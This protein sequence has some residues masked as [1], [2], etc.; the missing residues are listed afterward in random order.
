M[1]QPSGKDPVVNPAVSRRETPDL[2]QPTRTFDQNTPDNSGN[3]SSNLSDENPQSFGRYR[4]VAMLGKGG[5]GAVYR[6]IDEQLERH[7]AIKVT[8][9]SMLDSSTRNG[10][11]TEA[12][13]VAALD[14]PHIVPVYDVGQTDAGDFFVVSKLVDGSDLAKR[15]K[16][17]PPDR[18][19]SLRIIEQVADALHYAHAKG[20]VHRDVKPANILLDQQDRPYLADFGLA[21]RETE[22]RRAGDLSG[23]PAYMSPEQ[24]RGEGHRID[25]RSDIYS[26]GVVLYELLAGRRPFRSDNPLDLMMLIATEEVRSPRLFDDTISQDLERICMKALAR[27]VCDRFAVARDLAEEIRWLL[28]NHAMTPGIRPMSIAYPAG[29]TPVTPVT[30]NTADLAARATDSQRTGPPRI[31]PKGLRSFD[32][33]D[34]SFFLEL[35]PGPLDREGLPEGLRFWKSR[36]EETDPE[37]TFK[38][39]LVYG[40]SGC[41][42]SSLMKAGLLPRLSPRIIPIYL[43]V[44]PDDTETRLLRAVRKAIPDAEGDSLKE[45]LRVIRRRKLVPTGGKLLL[46]LDQFEQWLFGEKDFAKAQLTDALLQCDGANVQAIVMVRDDFWLSVSRFLRELEISIERSNSALVD[47]F[48]PDHAAKVLGLFGRAY[49]KL[50]AS[51]RD[52]SPDQHE[53]IRQAVQSLSQDRKIISVRI[54][55]L[56]DM[57]KSRAW[58]TAALREVGGIEGIGV[59]FLEETFGSRHA[60]IQHRQH[61]EGV[62]GLLSALMPIKGADLKGSMRNANSL[63][64]AAGYERRPLEFQELMGILVKDLRLITPVDDGNSVYDA[65]PDQ[66]LP[67]ENSQSYQL[68]H[69]YMVPSLRE[70]LTQKQ[71]ETKK[72]RA[73][74]KLA[75]RTAVWNANQEN[76]QLPT[77]LEWLQIRRWTDKGRWTASEQ[78]LMRTAARVH[79]K[80]WGSTLVAALILGAVIG[81]LFQQQNL[82]SQREK[83]AV[84]L[85]SIQNTAGP[86][87]PSNIARLI[88]MRRPDLVR[89]ELERRYAAAIEPREKLSLAFALAAFGQVE[90][91]YLISQLDVIQDRDTGNL[92]RALR[93]DRQG[94]IEKLTHAAGECE[95]PELWQRRARLSLAALGVGDAALPV[96]ACEFEGRTDHGL[97]TLFIDEFPRW[98]LDSEALVATVRDSGSPALRSAICMGLGQ[99]PVNQVSAKEKGRI[100][101]LAAKWFSLPDSSTHSAVEWL[102]REWKLPAPSLADANQMV[103]GRNWFVNSQGV[104]FVRI[105]P[106]PVTFKPLPDHPLEKARKYVMQMEDASP[107]DA[108]RNPFRIRYQTQQELGVSLFRIGQYQQAVGRF[109]E[110][111]KMLLQRSL[112]E[113]RSYFSDLSDLAFEQLKTPVDEQTALKALSSDVERLRLFSLARASHVTEAENA[114]YHWHENNPWPPFR[115]YVESVVPLFLGHKEQA[116][117]RLEKALSGAR[118]ADRFTLYNLARAAATFAASESFTAEEKRTWS[119]CALTLLQCWSRDDEENRQQLRTDYDWLVLHSDPRFVQ[120]AAERDVPDQPYWVANREVTRGEFEAFLH[121]F[122]YNGPK[123]ADPRASRPDVRI[124]PTLDHPAQRVAWVDAVMYCNWLSSKEG[125]KPAYRTVG[126]EKI[127]DYD[128]EFEIDKWEIEETADGYRLLRELEWKYVCRAGSET[129]WSSGNDESLLAS[130]CQMLPSKLA[131]P[132]TKKLANPWG[133]HD[134]HGNVNEWCWDHAREGH[135]AVG[136][137]HG[138]LA[139]DCRSTLQVWYLPMSNHDSTGFRLALSS[140]RI[141]K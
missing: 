17:D 3:V 130:Y 22:R 66:T 134:M 120:L 100:A 77:L 81:C 86:S 73:E 36:I 102:L 90:S 27:R 6:A 49:G 64:I 69:D 46:I 58:T 135:V 21:L 23:T 82:R 26:L 92:I 104:T 103:A 116:V 4:V 107:L 30:P 54:A 20:L 61:Q 55:V 37:Q 62:R 106:P 56:A 91:D 140:S 39:G 117:E 123:P 48:D 132:C 28:A 139:A 119:D 94:S 84:A 89:P 67:L 110:A 129:D 137:G 40:P 57:M 10:F 136:G 99:I 138:D 121:D 70:W 7:V 128:R 87:V 41:G 109:D 65:D 78:S 13:I 124:S 72:G 16:L 105:T 75:E 45:I 52:W 29:A 93:T 95:T 5:F 126:K 32:A 96:D 60:P 43:E 50:P 127:K 111:A 74:I 51:S 97:R 1:S 33:S 34:A 59:T 88:E 98:E 19:Q 9:G 79:V 112:E 44:T 113:S 38:V 14:H 8:H 76:K 71:R 101:E 35:L 108:D 24:A 83:I 118:S 15:I 125:R 133:V 12:R 122:S 31:V 115:D 11:L 80:T 25:N 141:S 131:S 2:D 18:I 68:A 63:Q 53:F 47:L 114:M 85:D 42:K